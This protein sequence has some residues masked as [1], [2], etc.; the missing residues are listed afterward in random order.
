MSEYKSIIA[1]VLD[2]RDERDKQLSS[3]LESSNDLITIVLRGHLVVEELLFAAVGAH[4]QDQEQ[5]KA[6]RLRFPQLVSILRALEKLP[7]LPPEYWAALSELNSLRNALAHNL[8]PKDLASRVLRFVASVEASA[9][10]T[11]LSVPVP[12][13][14]PDALK[15]AFHFL[16][17]GLG[18]LAVWQSAIEELIRHQLGKPNNAFKT[19]VPKGTRP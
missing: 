19:D 18:M 16:V 9:K 10:N 13:D 15:A 11:A 14:S 7:A 8:E 17:G 4:C 1:P 2:A 12:R 5:L 6:A 3:L